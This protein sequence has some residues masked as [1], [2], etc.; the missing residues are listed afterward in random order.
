MTC[1]FC[2]ILRSG[3]DGNVLRG[4]RVRE[5]RSYFHA[6]VETRRHRP[7]FVQR[8]RT[9]QQDERREQAFSETTQTAG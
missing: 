2:V 7:L 6:V 3:R 9:L 5:L 8:L 4:S 1:V